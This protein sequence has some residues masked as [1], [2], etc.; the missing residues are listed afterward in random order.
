MLEENFDFFYG[1]IQ[2][3]GKGATNKMKEKNTKKALQ[4]VYL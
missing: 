1:A 2:E 4:G 3:E